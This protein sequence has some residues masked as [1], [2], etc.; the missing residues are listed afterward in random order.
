MLT[1][2]LSAVQKWGGKTSDCAKSGGA[3]PK[4]HGNYKGFW[5]KFGKSGEPVAPPAPPWINALKCD[6]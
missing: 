4:I 1:G 3:K 5:P 6:Q 2:H